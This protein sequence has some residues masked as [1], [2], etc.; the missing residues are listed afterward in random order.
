MQIVLQREKATSL[1]QQRRFDMTLNFH[2]FQ[3]NNSMSN[4]DH[5]LQN[6]LPKKV[7][8]IRNRE[9]RQNSHMYGGR[10]L[11]L[12]FFHKNINFQFFISFKI[13]SSFKI[14]QK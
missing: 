3:I 13:K 10:S 6:V 7:H 9:T 4:S 8:E 2:N 5:K 1:W 14:K 11:S 12:I